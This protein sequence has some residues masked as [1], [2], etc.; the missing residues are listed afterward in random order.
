MEKEKQSLFE[1]KLGRN[2]W[3]SLNIVRIRT[4]SEKSAYKYL[5]KSATA[6]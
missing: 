3:S 6:Q 2:W 1:G 4:E 5:E